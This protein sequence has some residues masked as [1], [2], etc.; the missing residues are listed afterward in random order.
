[1]YGPHVAKFSSWHHSEAK[2]SRLVR[3][4]LERI[5]VTSVCDDGKRRACGSGSVVG[6]ESGPLFRFN[7]FAIFV[8]GWKLVHIRSR[9]NEWE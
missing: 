7:G 9:R 8:A 6:T 2:D 4:S 5:L 3:E 1:M